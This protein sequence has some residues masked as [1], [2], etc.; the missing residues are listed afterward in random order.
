[1]G[2][3]N[4]ADDFYTFMIDDDLKTIK[5]QCLLLIHHYGK[6]DEFVEKHKLDKVGS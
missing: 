3:I 4:F 2:K 5:K 6:I 1:M